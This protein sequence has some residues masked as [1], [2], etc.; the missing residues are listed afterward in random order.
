MGGD[1]APQATIAGALHAL[2]EL[3]KDHSVQLVGQTP[4]IERELAA[5]L[6]GE[7]AHCAHVRDRIDIVEA[8][9]LVDMGD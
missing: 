1:F 4:V 6:S 2:D 5:S 3:D 7:L 9:D 8:P